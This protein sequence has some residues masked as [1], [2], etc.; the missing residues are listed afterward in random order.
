MKLPVVTYK[1]YQAYGGDLSEDAFNASLPHA[2]SWL[3]YVLGYNE[4]KTDAENEA[5]IRATCSAIAVD[6]AYGAS[7]GIGEGAASMTIGSFSISGGSGSN[8]S[9][10]A[11]QSD[12]ESAIQRE[13]IGTRLLFQGL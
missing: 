7:G 11:Y 9:V 6:A 12:M 5:C 4:P 8:G 13:L 1:D 10:N 3:R 2:Q